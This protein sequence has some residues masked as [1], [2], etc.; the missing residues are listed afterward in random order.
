MR[1]IRIFAAIALM[2]M[3][4]STAV[5]QIVSPV[6]F[7]R[8]NP[9]NTFANPAFFTADYGYFD[10][11][12]G[13]VNV[14]LQ[15]TGLKY[16][17]FFRFNAQGQP[18]VLDLNSGIA[19]LRDKNYLNAYGTLDIFN[20]GRRTAHGFFTYS[21]RFRFF[22]TASYTKDLIA[23]VAQG[24][25]SYLGE[26]NPAN[27]NLELS[28]RMYQEFNFGYQM[29]LTENLNIGARVKFLMGFIDAK[30]QAM[31]MQLFTDP[32]TYALRLTADADIQAALP[33]EFTV[34]DGQLKVV[35]SRFNIANLFKNYGFGVD[36]GAEYKINDQFG[37]AA[38]VN[39]LGLIF[40]RN[41]PVRFTAGI[42][43]GGHYYDNGAFVFNGLTQN[44]LD[45]MMNDPDFASHLIDTLKGYIGITPTA[46]TGYNTGLN[47][48]MML[49]GYYDI[50]PEHRVSAQLMGYNMG[51]GL[52]PAFTV[53]YSGSFAENFDVVATYTMMQGS[54][55]NIG[56]GLS[57]NLG[58][59]MIYAA[60][61][62]VLGFFN[63][64]NVSQ[65]NLQVGIAF[66]ATDKISR[67]ETVVIKD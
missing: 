9:R 25:G 45:N 30:T 66:T 46:L 11:L 39:D 56:I 63:P 61:N 3:M 8:N 52:K 38:A 4:T 60:S 23:L 28:T 10:F 67:S 2:T 29:C 18:S 36:L 51:L 32:T 15:N 48:S 19:S 50:T 20:C 35:D 22:E 33:Y 7:M 41:H 31:N 26:G 6:D 34:V 14:G 53:A 55:D 21:H 43:D 12:L 42:Q 65:L 27:I 47:T 5:A 58:G 40:W 24:N 62:N 13:G 44:D 54:Y 59:F 37:V 64:A 1:H 57:A 17:K 16:D 49:R